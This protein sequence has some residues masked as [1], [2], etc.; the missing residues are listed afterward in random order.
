VFFAV[1]NQAT[2]MLDSLADYPRWFVVA[3]ATIVL[4]VGLWIGMKLLKIALWV[5]IAVVLV[6]GLG[7]AVWLLIK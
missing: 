4:A 5:L 6:V 2:T 3:C 7:A 1:V